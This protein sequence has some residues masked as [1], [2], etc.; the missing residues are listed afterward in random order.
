MKS[1]KKKDANELICRTKADSQTLKIN[2]VTE[3]DRCCGAGWTEGLGLTD[4]H[5][6]IRNHWPL[7]TCCIV[8]GNSRSILRWSIWEKDLKKN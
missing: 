1:K 5:C 3:G 8:Q 7:G 4:A 2:T 6:D